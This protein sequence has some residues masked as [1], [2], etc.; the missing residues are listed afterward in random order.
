[1]S[2]L[3]DLTPDD[4]RELTAAKDILGHLRKKGEEEE[5][6][7]AQIQQEGQV[8][9]EK[10]HQTRTQLDNLGEQIANRESHVRAL[11]DRHAALQ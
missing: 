5:A 2:Q 6:R 8:L 4:M 10:V 9:A 11:E 7:V 3:D 1:V